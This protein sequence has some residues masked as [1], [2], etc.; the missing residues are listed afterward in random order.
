MFHKKKGRSPFL[1]SVLYGVPSINDSTCEACLL[2]S[3]AGQDCS[4][5]KIL[6]KNAVVIARHLNRED[7]DL[8]VDRL[9]VLLNQ[10]KDVNVASAVFVDKLTVF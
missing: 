1:L 9:T 3:P 10:C 2:S 5:V 7:I 8:R 6:W 4:T